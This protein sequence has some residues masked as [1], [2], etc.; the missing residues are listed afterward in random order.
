ML[1]DLKDCHRSNAIQLEKGLSSAKLWAEA[2]IRV[3]EAEVT[4]TL[5]DKIKE[6]VAA[7]IKTA[8]QP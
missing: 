4:D 3:T 6:W 1:G 8:Q 7:L 2:K 5:A